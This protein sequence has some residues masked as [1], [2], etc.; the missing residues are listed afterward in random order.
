MA[1]AYVNGSTG[2]SNAGATTLA[3]AAFAATTGNAIFVSI[4]CQSTK[5]VSSIADTAG[6]T[7]S[8]AG[9]YISGVNTVELWF[10]QNITG[11]ASNVVTVTYSGSATKRRVSVTQYSGCATSSIQDTGY[12]PAGN[13]DTTSPKQ[14][15]AATTAS[16]NEVVIAAAYD[17]E[18]DTELL[19]AS[20]GT[21]LR[22]S[23]NSSDFTTCER[24]TT[25]AGS[26]NTGFTGEDDQEWI[27][28]ARAFNPVGAVAAARTKIIWIPAI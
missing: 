18:D 19:T 4:G 12:A 2:K 5:T 20:S 10:A 11:N 8:R 21:T 9:Q 26:Y 17:V 6:N 24:I 14:S 28:I 23:I 1:I 27:F 16:D 25:T 13:A 3:A 7:Y 22:Q 15:T